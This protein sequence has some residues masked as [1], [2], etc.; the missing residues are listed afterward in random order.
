MRRILITYIAVTLV[1]SLGFFGIGALA[2]A[3]E[4]RHTIAA[5]HERFANMGDELAD[6]KRIL[7]EG[8]RLPG[9]SGGS[10]Q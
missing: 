2:S 10:G 6:I 4:L 8:F 9:A 3:Q 5:N 1:L 7:R